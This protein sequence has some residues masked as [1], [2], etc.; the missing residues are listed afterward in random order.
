MSELDFYLGH[1]IINA[2]APVNHST[3]W[4]SVIRI[5]PLPE[6]SFSGNNQQHVQEALRHSSIYTQDTAHRREKTLFTFNKLMNFKRYG[7]KTNND[8]QNNNS[9]L[10]CTIWTSSFI[11]PF[12]CDNQRPLNSSASLSRWRNCLLFWIW[13]RDY[14]TTGWLYGATT[15]NTSPSSIETKDAFL[16]TN[17]NS[18]HC[19]CFSVV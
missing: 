5:L 2:G 3:I 16:S 19:D 15:H 7:N 1:I 17:L 14:F 13:G 10:L 8:L 11:F 9:V 4:L 18:S 12:A 6:P